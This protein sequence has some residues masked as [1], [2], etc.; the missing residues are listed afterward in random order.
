MTTRALALVLLVAWPLQPADDALLGAVRAPHSPA[1]TAVARVA[2]DR[3]RPALFVAAGIALLA[4]GVARAVAVETIAVLV[5]V[6]LVVEGLKRLTYRTRPD[7]SHKRSN[8]AFP[9]SHAANAFAVATVIFRRWRRWGLVAFALAAVVAWSRLYLNRHWP[10][11]VLAGA[12]LAVL[13]ALV[14][15]RALERWRASRRAAATP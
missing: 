4:G 6:N 8:A 15:L 2:S 12:L 10:S 1:L 5:P 13:L 9:S 7:G 3:S 11:D 14:T